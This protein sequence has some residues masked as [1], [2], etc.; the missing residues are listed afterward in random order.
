MNKLKEKSL[1]WWRLHFTQRGIKKHNDIYSI[2][3]D[4]DKLHEKHYM[5]NAVYNEKNLNL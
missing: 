1:C 4:S 3:A 2:I 5:I